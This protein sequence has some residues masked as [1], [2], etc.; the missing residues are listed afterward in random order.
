MTMQ[1]LLRC[2]FEQAML[3]VDVFAP[4]LIS[5]LSVNTALISLYQI[6]R[7][8]F[9]FYVLLFLDSQTSKSKLLGCYLLVVL[10]KKKKIIVIVSEELTFFILCLFLFSSSLSLK[11]FL[12][13][14]LIDN[15]IVTTMEYV[16][17]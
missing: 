7:F 9:C 11:D 2:S 12:F 3:Q 8:L 16:I 10:L 6:S 4:W 5:S 1:L 13:Y 14:F 15:L 17:Y